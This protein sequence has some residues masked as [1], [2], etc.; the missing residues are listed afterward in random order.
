MHLKQFILFRVKT[1]HN[2]RTFIEHCTCAYWDKIFFLI[3]IRSES[4]SKFCLLT[5]L[6]TD[7]T[8][9]MLCSNIL[10]KVSSGASTGFLMSS[11]SWLFWTSSYM[12]IISMHWV[13]TSFSLCGH[14]RKHQ[15]YF[16]CMSSVMRRGGRE[17][18]RAQFRWWNRRGTVSQQIHEGRPPWGPRAL[19][20]TSARMASRAPIFSHRSSSPASTLSI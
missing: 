16:V 1:Q 11:L 13:F 19:T 3:F 2:A 7:T 17:D 12:L 9:L 18:A 5:L 4:S 20:S 8:V 10:T 15:F 14:N 6:G